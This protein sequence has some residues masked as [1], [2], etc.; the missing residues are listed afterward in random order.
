[1]TPDRFDPARLP[2]S[3]AQIDLWLTYY[4]P[5]A[6]PLFQAQ[7]RALLSDAERAQEVRFH[8]PDDRLRYLVTR[9]MART[10]LSRYAGVA[11]SA[12]EFEH[13]EYGR[14]AIA[15]R[16][17]L[18]ALR[19]NVSHARGLIALAVGHGRELGVDVENLAERQA[20]IGVAER[21]FAA[22]E[23]AALRGVPEDRQH[24]RFFEYWTLKESY[25]KA[26]GMGLSL[27]LEQFAF[28]LPPAGPVQLQVAPALGDD[29][30]RWRFWQCQLA[31]DYLLALCADGDATVTLRHTVPTMGS[32]ELSTAWLR[33]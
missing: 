4:Q 2:C 16:H 19:F 22:A 3:P 14:P 13:N 1:M 15:K 18:T 25:I 7:L 32:T 31:P 26:R 28:H 24:A 9:A 17:A 6:D 12:W 23:V 20:P 11:P 30:A 33:G 10:V 8:F 21:F 27:P 5:L 29:G